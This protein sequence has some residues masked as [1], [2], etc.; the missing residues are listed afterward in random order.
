MR[1]LRQLLQSEPAAIG[2]LVAS[3]LPVLILLGVLPTLTDTE[4]AAIVV[5]VNAVVGFCIRLSVTP[6]KAPEPEVAQLAR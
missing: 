4:V 1:N 5:A 3:I 2:T 6:A